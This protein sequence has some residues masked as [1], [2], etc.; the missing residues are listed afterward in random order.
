LKI[1][2][3]RMQTI[4]KRIFFDLTVSSVVIPDFLEKSLGAG[5]GQGVFFRDRGKLTA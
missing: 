4:E 3:E 5:A 2:V 1:V